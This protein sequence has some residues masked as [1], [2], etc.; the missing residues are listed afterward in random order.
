MACIMGFPLACRRLLFQALRWLD[1]AAMV[2]NA[3]HQLRRIPAFSLHNLTA[4]APLT[5]YLF[6]NTI[7][8][9]LEIVPAHNFIEATE[10]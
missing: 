9:V 1:P 2:G 6:L 5:P 7:P 4:V 8:T 3:L 10:T